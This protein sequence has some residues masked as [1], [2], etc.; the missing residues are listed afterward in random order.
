MLAQDKELSRGTG[1]GS[2]ALTTIISSPAAAPFFSKADSWNLIFDFLPS[3]GSA[4]FQPPELAGKDD[5]DTNA[6]PGAG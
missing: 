2:P 3:A 1:R 4:L 6:R 5:A